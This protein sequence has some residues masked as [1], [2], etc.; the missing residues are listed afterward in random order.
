MRD[1]DRGST[2]GQ[3][4][5]AFHADADLPAMRPLVLMELC[6]TGKPS[7]AASNDH[8]REQAPP[9]QIYERVPER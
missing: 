4:I 8:A 2:H 6:L 9:R 5:T 1:V 7:A 3:G